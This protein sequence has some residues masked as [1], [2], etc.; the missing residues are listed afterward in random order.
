MI[1]TKARNEISIADVIAKRDT[2][3]QWC[4]HATDYAEQHLGK[5]WNYLLVPHDVVAEN[6]TL[7][8]LVG[9]FTKKLTHIPSQS[10]S[11]DLRQKKPSHAESTQ[12]KGSGEKVNC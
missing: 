1:E 12:W 10:A 7:P 11:D 6:M 9:Q 3:V 5:P 4:K 2:A 8:G